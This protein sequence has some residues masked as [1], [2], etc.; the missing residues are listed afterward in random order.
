MNEHH[1]AIIGAGTMGSGIAQKYAS[2]AFIVS[3]IDLKQENLKQAEKSIR[4]MLDQALGRGLFSEAQVTD[5]MS[6]IKFSTDLATI[7][8]AGLIIEAI[9]EDYSLKTK[10]FQ[11]IENICEPQALI[12]SNTSSFLIADLQRDFKNPERFLGLHYFYHPAKNRLV[13]VIATAKTSPKALMRAITLQEKIQK[14]IIQSKD[15]PGFIV[16]R[17]FVPWLNEAM[18]IVHEGHTNIATVEQAAKSFFAISMGPFELMNITGMSITLH[19]ALSLSKSLGDFYAPCP[20]IL[21]QIE[22]K[23][24]WSLDGEINHD[25]FTYINQR[26][27]SVVKDITTRLAVDEKVASISDIDLGARVGLLWAKGPFELANNRPCFHKLEVSHQNDIAIIK[28]N[29]PDSMNALDERLCQELEE[30]FFTISEDA[31]VK[32]IIITGH[33]RAFMAG[34]DLS[35]FNHHVMNQQIDT[36]VSFAARAQ[37]LFLSIDRSKKPVV[38]A[39]SGLALGGGLEL[40][41]ACDKIVATIDATLGFPETGIGIYPGLGGTQ[42]TPLRI[43]IPLAK[44]L[45][46]T[47]TLLSGT[48]AHVIGLIDQCSNGPDLIAD[49]ISLLQQLISTPSVKNPEPSNDAFKDLRLAFT[50]PFSQHKNQNLSPRARKALDKIAQKAPLALKAANDLIS[51]ASSNLE[52]GLHEETS[53]L[54]EIFKSKDAQQGLSAALSKQRVSFEGS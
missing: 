16:N 31:S 12:A 47:G 50:D 5:I 52:A 6:R 42:R 29:R 30:A 33:Q 18:R 45:V 26:L 53:R 23:T 27:F 11:D 46:L 32:G 20:L 48:E 43:G 38:A 22:R 44:F 35:F 21:D 8:D 19:A 2:S 4:A 39:I 36:I 54:S 34:A 17:F 10:L 40:A 3:I 41:L 9:F 28:F 7:A 25:Q 15:S 1:I 24:D 14:I 51:L 49:S 37:K 13:E